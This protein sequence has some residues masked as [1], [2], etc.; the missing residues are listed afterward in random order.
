MAPDLL[1]EGGAKVGELLGATDTEKA[2]L[3]KRVAA[4]KEAGA[5]R[6]AAGTSGPKDTLPGG[7]NVLD[8]VDAVPSAESRNAEATR[9]GV[10]PGA[11]IIGGGGGASTAA[12]RNPEAIRAQ[13]NSRIDTKDVEAVTGVPRAPAAAGRA[14]GP[15]STGANTTESGQAADPLAVTSREAAT[16]GITQPTDVLKWSE[17]ERVWMANTS[18]TWVQAIRELQLPFAAGPSGMTNSTLNA[19]QMLGFGGQLLEVRMA[20]IGFLL[21]IHA[22]SLVE[23]LTAGAGFGLPFTAG[24][25]MYEGIP[26]LTKADL[27][28]C[29]KDGK[30][31][32]E[33][34]SAPA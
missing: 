4:A 19:A 1:K 12:A 18:E 33:L 9:Q 31:P 32:K 21:N 7:T 16:Q 27:L 24:P 28:P 11:P 14:A 34:A 22:H 15:I 29:T 3:V 6:A 10:A 23:I 30:F 26:P 2:E 20:C 8:I 17:G 13:G 5:A 25:E